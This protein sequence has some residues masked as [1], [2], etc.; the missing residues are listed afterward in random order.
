MSPEDIC[1]KEKKASTKET[2]E[3]EEDGKTGMINI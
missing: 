3:I 1:L 2:D